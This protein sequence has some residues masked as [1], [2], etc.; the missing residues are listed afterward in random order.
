MGAVYTVAVLRQWGQCSCSG[1]SSAA[2][3]CDSGGSV[4]AGSGSVCCAGAFI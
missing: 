1:W 3:L 2:V 4:A